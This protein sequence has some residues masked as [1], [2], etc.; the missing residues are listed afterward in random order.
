MN[1]FFFILSWLNV[2]NI[3]IY[4]LHT[5][6]WCIALEARAVLIWTVQKSAVCD[7]KPPVSVPEFPH[8]PLFLLLALECR[9]MS[10]VTEEIRLVTGSEKRT[11]VYR[12]HVTEHFHWTCDL[13]WMD[14]GLNYVMLL[15][16]FF[17]P[18]TQSGGWECSDVISTSITF[19]LLNWTLSSVQTCKID[20]KNF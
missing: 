6:K 8:H 20:T 10:P 9:R 12:F 7:L 15:F 16:Y 4:M 18:V 14:E 1:Q 5:C 13:M 19:C 17:S 2:S 11:D 3:Y